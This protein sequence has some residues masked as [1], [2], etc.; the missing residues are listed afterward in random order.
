MQ[1]NEQFDISTLAWVK[2]EIDET[3]NQARI[4]LESF[5]D[6][7]NETAHLSQFVDLLHQVHGTLKIVEIT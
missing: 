7:E 3:L 4:A 2:D 1:N 6:D 5:V